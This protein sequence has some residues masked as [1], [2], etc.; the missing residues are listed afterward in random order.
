MTIGPRVHPS[1][2][3][4]RVDERVEPWTGVGGGVG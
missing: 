4:V 2:D 3:A 1:D